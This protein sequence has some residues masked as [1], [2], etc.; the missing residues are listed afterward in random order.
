MK[1]IYEIIIERFQIRPSDNL[2]FRGMAGTRNTIA[3]IMGEVG[4]K[5][6]AE[7]GVCEG[8]FSEILFKTIP[9][10]KLYCVDP[11]CQYDNISQVFA[12]KRFDDAVIRLRDYDAVFKKT[13]SMEAIQDVPDKSLDFIYIDGNHDYNYVVMDIIEWS[14]KVKSGGIVSGHDYYHFYKAGVVYAVDAYTRAH[15][16]YNWYLT[17]EREP[18]WFW[19]NP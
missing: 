3:E 12:Q 10:L 6:G 17:R 15:Q 1:S 13:T 14:K 4:F 19:V 2:P 18:S 9:G 11:W 5:T 7:I 16:I 8:L